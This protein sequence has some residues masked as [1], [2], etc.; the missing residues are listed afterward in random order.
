MPKLYA[1][2]M[3]GLFLLAA[4]SVAGT[5]RAD[6][7]VYE[8]GPG[9]SWTR[10]VSADGYHYAS[11]SP[12]AD[13]ASWAVDGSVVASGAGLLDSNDRGGDGR[14]ADL[15]AD[16]R[17]LV[18]VGPSPDG[19]GL[20]SVAVN[21]RAFGGAFSSIKGVRIG[22]R[23]AN[24]V[25]LANQ[26]GKGCSVVSVAGPG[27]AFPECPS[28]VVATDA[29]VIYAAKWGVRT[30]IYRDHQLV[31]EKDYRQLAASPDLSRFAGFLDDG[32]EF[33]YVEIGTATV[34]KRRS[35]SEMMFSSDGRHF[36]VMGGETSSARDS[37]IVDGK[38]YP[39]PGVRYLSLRPGDG[40]PFWVSG[41]ESS[42]HTVGKDYGRTGI[43]HH[44]WNTG[45]SWLAFSPSGRHHAF[46]AWDRGAKADRLVVDG[47]VL[48]LAPPSPLDDA[49]IVFDGENEF[50]YLGWRKADD[51]IRLVCATV[52]GSS[53]RRT[54][55]ARFA[56]ARGAKLED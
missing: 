3:K 13:K 24:V 22:R 51:S 17:V 20:Y 8:L 48:E 5:A 40:A 54:R 7:A 33:H 42:F 47:E 26:A 27:P 52:D 15:S 18:T 39:A 37:V 49:R 4:L 2:A 56:A 43:P 31:A 14:T 10:L 45:G 11:F 53:A 9:R 16:G 25:F 50:H 38:S 29:G 35:L 41:D 55:C 21:G 23:G 6:V 44:I 30:L 36:G 12:G 32:K 1:F 46:A 34:A 28:P 19:S